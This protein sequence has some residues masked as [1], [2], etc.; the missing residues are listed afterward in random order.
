M[1]TG[2]MIARKVEHYLH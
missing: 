1:L 2:M